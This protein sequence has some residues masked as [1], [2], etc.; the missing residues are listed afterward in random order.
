MAR[1]HHD[2]LTADLIVLALRLRSP[3]EAE[4]EHLLVVEPLAGR[5]EAVAR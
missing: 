4:R 5:F 3:V 2:V 1:A